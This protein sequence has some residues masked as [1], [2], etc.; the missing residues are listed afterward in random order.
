MYLKNIQCLWQMMYTIKLFP[1]LKFEF[2]AK[3]VTMS[4]NPSFIFS[5]KYGIL[6]NNYSLIIMLIVTTQATMDMSGQV[7]ISEITP[8]TLLTL[9][10]YC[11]FSNTESPTTCNFG[12]I[13]E[14]ITSK[15]AE[16]ENANTRQK[17]QLT[18]TVKTDPS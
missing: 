15:Q 8:W 2:K 17:A 3:L 11:Q 5:I 14:D 12:V 6:S 1:C 10:L 18:S 13:E 4:L 16:G 7:V 9:I